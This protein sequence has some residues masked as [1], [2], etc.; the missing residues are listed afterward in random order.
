[1]FLRISINKII[2]ISIIFIVFLHIT[3]CGLYRKTDAREI[4]TNA[5]D[6]MAKNIEEGDQLN[7][8]ILVEENLEVSILPHL[9]K[10][11][12]QQLKF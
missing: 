6:R 1:M 11:G 4:P 5:K 12:E 10:C 8:V 7:L 3:Q 2:K 9:M